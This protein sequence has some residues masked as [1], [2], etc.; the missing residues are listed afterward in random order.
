MP[1]AGEPRR[2]LMAEKKTKNYG[3]QVLF[4]LGIIAVFLGG[5]LTYGGSL[6]GM[7]ILVVGVATLVGVGWWAVKNWDY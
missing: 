1:R 7:A 3:S 6:V 2:A 5:V 4:I